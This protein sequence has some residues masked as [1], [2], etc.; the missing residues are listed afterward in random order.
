MTILEDRGVFWW[1]D[2]AVPAGHFAPGSAVAGLLKIEE[3]GRIALELDSYMPSDKGPLSAV[4]NLEDPSIQDRSIQGCLKNSGNHVLLLDLIKTGSRFSTSAMSFEKYGAMKCLVSNKTFPPGG[5]EMK[6]SSLEVDLD[7]FEEWLGLNS[8]EIDKSEKGVTAEY[9]KPDDLVYGLDDGSLAVRYDIWGPVFSHKDNVVSLKEHASVAYEPIAKAPLDKLQVKYGL[10]EDLFILLTG[11]EY[12]LQWPFVKICSD[13]RSRFYFQRIKSRESTS[14]PNVHECWT[15]FYQ[16]RNEFGSVWKRWND[17][18]KEFGAGFYL[19]LG[20]RRGI[21]LYTEHRFVNLIWGIEA[22]HRKRQPVRQSSAL[23]RKIERIIDQV[24]S[25]K[26]KKWLAH[27]LT[28][29]YEPSL[30]DRIF[31]AFRALPIGIEPPRLRNFA[32]GCAELRNQISH[33]GGPRAGQY[34]DFLRK[35]DRISDVLSTLYHTLVLSEIGILPEM[36]KWYIYQGAQS[37]SIKRNFIEVG[38]L[39]G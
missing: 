38:L 28:Y 34:S 18:R 30:E 8:I 31:E 33:Y 32:K 19:Y 15:N 35:L 26:D 24:S 17:K 2:Q 6:F 36:L 21:R 29:A 25:G 13:H 3:D 1:H 16:I 39:E 11:S 7:G 5:G 22:L 23:S 14:P 4:M 12:C 20:T 9:K 10:L 27:K 37:Y